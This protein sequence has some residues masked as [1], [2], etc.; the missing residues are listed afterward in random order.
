MSFR[1][2]VNLFS[3]VGKRAN[4]TLSTN[5]TKPFLP[6]GVSLRKA[7]ADGDGFSQSKLCETCPGS[8]PT[9]Q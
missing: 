9:A 4:H 1:F 8:W 5:S 7:K 3:P 2:L 6:A